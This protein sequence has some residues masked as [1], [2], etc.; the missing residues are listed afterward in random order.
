MSRVLP[1]PPLQTNWRVGRFAPSRAGRRTAVS[2]G[3]SPQ[4]SVNESDFWTALEF[5]VCGELARMP[6]RA[7]RFLWCDG[8]LPTPYTLCGET[9]RIEGAVWMLGGR[10][11]G[12]WRYAL[13]MNHTASAGDTIRWDMLV[14]GDQYG[15][16][17][18]LD[19]DDRMLTVDVRGFQVA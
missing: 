8:F 6:D 19:C 16:W 4:H 12:V 11:S 13:L 7:S 1:N 10:E 5:R 14:P 18:V 17:L 2:L 9:P 15:G 3:D